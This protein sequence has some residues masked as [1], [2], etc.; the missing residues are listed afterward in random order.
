[1]KKEESL[2]TILEVSSV[3]NQLVPQQRK[4]VASQ[5]SNISYIDVQ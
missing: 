4:Y 1:M 3:D 5:L 2:L